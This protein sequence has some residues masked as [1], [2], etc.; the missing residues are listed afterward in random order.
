VLGLKKI[1]Q[2]AKRGNGQTWSSLQ[3]TKGDVVTQHG[4]IAPE[5][6]KYKGAR[7][8]VIKKEKK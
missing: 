3:S 5:K 2:W 6:K 8:L 1:Q 7:M 4:T